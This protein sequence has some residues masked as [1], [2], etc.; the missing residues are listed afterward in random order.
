MSAA[1]IALE[2]AVHA[3]NN[4]DEQGFLST[5][6]SDIELAAPGGLNFHGREGFQQWYRLWTDAFPDGSV[7]YHNLEGDADQVIGEGVF[8]GTQ[9]GVL[10]LPSGDVPPTNRKVTIDFAA[11]VR[12]EDGQIR[13]LRHYLDVMDL[14]GQL[15]LLGRD[16][17]RT[18]A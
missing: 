10:H 17:Q 2:T 14:M 4:R 8:T 18:P 1:R 15:G 13:Y 6:R 9:A 16:A 12:A 7:R 3:L 11:V 5:G